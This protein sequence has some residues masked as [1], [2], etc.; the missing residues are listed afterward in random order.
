MA[1]V[2]SLFINAWLILST[3]KYYQPSTHSR[4]AASSD[5]AVVLEGFFLENL[6]G[7]DRILRLRRH[8]NRPGE[9]QARPRTFPP[10]SSCPFLS[11]LLFSCSQLSSRLSYT[12]NSNRR[13]LLHRLI[14]TRRLHQSR[15]IRLSKALTSD[16]HTTPA[17]IIFN[18]Y[19]WK[20]QCIAALDTGCARTSRPHWYAHALVKG[21]ASYENPC[22][23][24]CFVSFLSFLLLLLS[25]S[26][27]L[28]SCLS[29]HR[30]VTINHSFH[31]R[32]I[33]NFV[34][35]LKLFHSATENPHF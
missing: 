27:H 10:I 24:L 9:G 30:L 25:S 22:R 32:L 1:K 7:N 33:Q 28:S 31:L 19:C 3:D 16:H 4:Y 21:R 15:S 17:P 13:G 8:A 5:G 29:F 26:T 12:L 6:M 20:S 34:S 23:P 35:P 2:F 18:R 14:Q 11:S